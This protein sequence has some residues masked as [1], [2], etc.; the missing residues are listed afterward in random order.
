MS[1]NQPLPLRPSVRFFAPLLRAIAWVLM[2]LLGPLRIRHRRAI[3]RHGPV[4]IVA[5]HLADVDPVVVQLACPRHIR[6]MAKSELFEM[7]NI[8]W[9]VGWWGGFPVTR[10]EPDRAA[11]RRA[12]EHLRAGEAVCLFPEGQLSESAEL[13]PLLPGAA[14]IA[15]MSGAP[16][17]ACRIDE[18]HRIMPY[19]RVIPRPAFRWV[20]ATWSEAWT[21]PPGTS[22]EAILDW[23]REKLQPSPKPDGLVNT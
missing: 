8:G 3:P 9:F 12:V 10:G 15:R 11:L 21:P 18:T 17:V 5:N 16:I 13:L 14:L 4:L 2:T 23:M 22:H 19:G 6:F 20:T 7:R 1:L